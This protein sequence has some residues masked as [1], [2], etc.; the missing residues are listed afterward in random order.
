[1]VLPKDCNLRVLDVVYV[2]E[3]PFH[4]LAGPAL[5][6]SSDDPATEEYFSRVL[7]NDGA[8]D[9]HGDSTGLPWWRREL[10][11]SDHGI[12]L[13]IDHGFRSDT[14]AATEIL[15]YAAVAAVD[16]YSDG[17]NGP[18]G[19]LTPPRSS[20]P[21][22]GGQGLTTTRATLPC[23]SLKLYAL[24]LDS[25]RLASTIVSQNQDS[26]GPTS[27][28]N[29]DA[30]FILH[31]DH[32]TIDPQTLTN[33][34][35]K[36]SN[37]FDDATFQRRKLKGRGGESISQAMAEV[38]L[39]Q[40]G[41]LA[42]ST[43][44]SQTPEI[45]QQPDH[46]FHGNQSRKILSRASSAASLTSLDSS[47]PPSRR[48]A[49]VAG[50]RSALSRVESVMSNDSISGENDNGFEQQ[51]K[52]AL[53]RIVMAGMRMYGLQQQK[54]PHK[55]QPSHHSISPDIVIESQQ[56]TANGRAEDPD[57]YK[58]IYHQTF[59]AACF[60]FRAH[61]AARMV[62]QEDMREIVDRLLSLFCVDPLQGLEN[63]KLASEVFGSQ[64]ERP[65][66]VFDQPSSI[67]VK[68]I[69]V[70]TPSSRK[71]KSVVEPA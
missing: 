65:R 7:L 2:A 3:I 41:K 11:Q 43:K 22:L 23:L 52:A 17:S 63:G 29:G 20:S 9:L 50:K 55:P 6:L 49:F 64:E 28:S 67:A 32:D 34:R 26:A 27:L 30:R 42:E 57:E 39:Q 46:D 36:L 1:M 14:I 16:G 5:T 54:K 19:M 51:N 48:S 31:R 25:R 45:P 62:P 13:K 70:E 47:R 37:V 66:D 8:G 38:G 68:A 12:L 58:A 10:K 21:V 71:G 60:A 59:K 33:K 40:Q 35:R 69:S 24:P 18:N 53:A 61:L 56:A 15:I 4:L 44:Q